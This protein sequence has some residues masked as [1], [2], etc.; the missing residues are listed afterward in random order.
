MS[1]TGTTHIC[2]L[3]VP[4]LTSS[5]SGAVGEGRSIRHCQPGILGCSQEPDAGGRTRA[6]LTLQP[7]ELSHPAAQLLQADA[8]W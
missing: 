2:F 4:L 5:A 3:A 7:V 8:A 1:L 6:G